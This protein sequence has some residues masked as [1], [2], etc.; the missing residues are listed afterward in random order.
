MLLREG[1]FLFNETITTWHKVVPP[2]TKLWEACTSLNE[3][4]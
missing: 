4:L 1:N 2:Y 3:Q